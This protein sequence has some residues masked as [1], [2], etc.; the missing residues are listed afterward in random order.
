MTKPRTSKLIGHPVAALKA[1]SA[2]ENDVRTYFYYD[3]RAWRAIH[4]QI[5]TAPAHECFVIDCLTD[6]NGEP[7]DIPF[8]RGTGAAITIK[9]VHSYGDQYPGSSVKPVPSTVFCIT[10]E[11]DYVTEDGERTT[12]KYEIDVPTE[13]ED[14]CTTDEFNARWNK[15]IDYL[16][17]KRRATTGAAEIA[18]LKRLAA[19][20][21]D[22][23]RS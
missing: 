12:R 6:W 17:A 15:W 2:M 20:Y 8:Y 23:L 11:V 1:I 22:A 14:D 21:P 16:K 5:A 3:S 7:V 18:E 13:L 9:D 10:I 19:K 4:T